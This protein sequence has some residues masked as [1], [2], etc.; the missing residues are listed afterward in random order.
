MA[1]DQRRTTN[2]AFQPNEKATRQKAAFSSRE[3]S[4]NGGKAVKTF[5][6]NLMSQKRG[7]SRN[8]WEI[9]INLFNNL[10]NRLTGFEIDSI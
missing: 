6:R 1:N 9:N 10:Q 3:N 5:W 4:S 2:G 8:F 7:V